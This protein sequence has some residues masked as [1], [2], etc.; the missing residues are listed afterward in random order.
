[1]S[2]NK[3][4]IDG[5]ANDVRMQQPN[6]IVCSMLKY[7][8]L[9]TVGNGA[10][11]AAALLS[12]IINRTGPAGA[13]ADTLPTADAILAA[14]P[15]L[16]QGDSFTAIIR[17]TVAFANT[18]TTN[19]G[20]VLG[21]DTAIA[22]SLVREFLFTVL[23]KGLAG[24]FSGTTVNASATVTGLT[25]DQ[26]AQLAPGMGVTGTGIPALTTII[27]VNSTLGTL[28]LSAAATASGTVGLTF[29]NR[30]SVEGVRSST[31]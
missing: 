2:Q 19:T 15:T 14:A 3:A 25:Q 13:Y 30:I 28:T 9:A 27:G 18:I 17:N 6:E 22:A 5:S 26:A 21:T 10:I 24:I 12:G 16:N 8:G 4:R 7:T 29:F 11:S 23:S 20:M 31:L 1:M